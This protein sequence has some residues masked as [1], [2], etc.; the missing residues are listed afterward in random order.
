MLLIDHLI[1]SCQYISGK[2]VEN[3]ILRHAPTL[4]HIALTGTPYQQIGDFNAG[5]PFDLPLLKSLSLDDFQFDFN[6]LKRFEQC[7]EL[8]RLELGSLDEMNPK[9]LM[10][11]LER[12]GFPALKEIMLSSDWPTAEED[13]NVEGLE[14]VC[15]EKGIGLAFEPPDSDDEDGMSFEG[16]DAEN[17]FWDEGFTEDEGD[18]VTDEDDG[19]F[20]DE[21][22]MIDDEDI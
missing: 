18:D 5:G 4:R 14:L 16:D 15:F 9:L 11:L 8:T 7:P 19:E 22:D 1:R 13:I 6:T 2:G 21:A 20:A 12:N 10:Q 17:E 3:F